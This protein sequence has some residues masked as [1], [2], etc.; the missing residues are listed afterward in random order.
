[1]FDARAA[2]EPG[3]FPK[4]TTY[5]SL[6]AD[7]RRAIDI[8]HRDGSLKQA[9]AAD[10]ARYI[11]ADPSIVPL[12]RMLRRSGKKVFLLTN[13]LFDYSSV[14]MNFIVSNRV[15]QERNLDW[16]S[17]FDVVVVGA[18][19]PTFFGGTR[20]MF[21]V[22]PHSGMLSNTDNGSPLAAIGTAPWRAVLDPAGPAAGPPVPLAPGE[23]AGGGP[24]SK[25]ASTVSPGDGPAGVPGSVTRVF[26]GGSI[27][28]LHA[29]LG[30]RSG[31]EVLYVGDHIF[32]DIIAGKT[33]IG[34]RTL[35]VVPELETE[36]KVAA[37]HRGSIASFRSLR[38]RR[39]ALDDQVGAPSPRF[40][41]LPSP[42]AR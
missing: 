4:G 38:Q 39:D 31:Q 29:M 6:Y 8:C 41:S 15:G 40:P 11:H 18:A 10:P 28:P 23:A 33:K 1:M 16:L 42:P 12:L 30:V 14:V 34:W 26:Q 36:L 19:K 3:S 9:V 21:E 27:A 17:L 25:A 20:P 35:L 5:K 7:V 2:A 22:D 24:G 32:G 13:S 37:K